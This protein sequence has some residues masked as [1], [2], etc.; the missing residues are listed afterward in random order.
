MPLF[1]TL[2]PWIGL[3]A[4]GALLSLLA[5]SDGLQAD[6]RIS[7]WFDLQWLLWLTVAAY[8]LHQFE[9][10]GVSL[11]G[12]PYAFRGA[13]CATLGYGDAVACP[14][15][16]AFITAVN[17][18]AVW[19]AGFAS[20][21]VARR[22]PLVG[23]SFLS[24]PLVNAFVHIVPAVLERRYNPGLATAVVLFLPLCLWTLSV[25][26]RRHGAGLRELAL[27]VL[28]G[29]LVHAVLM[30]SLMAYLRGFLGVAPL[31]A[32]QILNAA[33]PAAI[34]IVGTR[35]TARPTARPISNSAPSP[36]PA[37]PPRAPRRPRRA[38]ESG[39]P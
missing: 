17:V 26:V 14:I 20:A 38:A 18:S 5:A 34:L 8:L 37:I 21:L 19:V 15:P 24:V 30:G 12:A 39:R 29:V 25:A 27:L 9:E 23:L 4:A 6:R 7:R 31:V 36:N 1:A 35:R 16:L 3:G 22:W 13:L 32:I 10:H 2:W 33:L 28:A 11:F